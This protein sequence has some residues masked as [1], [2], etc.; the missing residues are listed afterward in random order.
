MEVK[1]IQ[2]AIR[3]AEKF[4]YE[5]ESCSMYNL[6]E[7]S[8][9]AEIRLDCIKATLDPY[10]W[11]CL[12]RHEN[13]RRPAKSVYNKEYFTKDSSTPTELNIETEDAWLHVWKSLPDF[14]VNNLDSDV[15]DFFIDVLSIIKQGK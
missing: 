11:E 2:E 4:G 7:S 12:G 14:L 15:N 9:P 3:R 6:D 8:A 13:W 1:Y 5:P 10:F